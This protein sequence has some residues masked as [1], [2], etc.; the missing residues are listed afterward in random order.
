LAVELGCSRRTVHRDLAT[1]TAAEVPWYYDEETESYR[2]RAGFRFPALETSETPR[3]Q[4]SIDH[5]KVALA[6]QKLRQDAETFMESVR[7]FCRSL[8]AGN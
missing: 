8:D 5:D 2:V 1:L 3:N 7:H 4:K 6:A